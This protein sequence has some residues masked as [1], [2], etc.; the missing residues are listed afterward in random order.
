VP[1]PAQDPPAQ[2]AFHRLRDRLEPDPE[3]RWHEARPLVHRGGGG[4][5]RDDSTRDQ[6]HA[7]TREGG[8]RHGSGTHPSVVSGSNRSTVAWSDGAR[9]I[10][11]DSRRDDPAHDGPTT[12]DHLRALRPRATNRGFAPDRVR[13]D[14]GPSRWEHRQTSRDCGG[15]GRTPPTGKR[16]VHPE[17][18]GPR[19]VRPV[20]RAPAGTVVPRAGDGWVRVVTLVTRDGDLDCWAPHDLARAE[21]ERLRRAAWSWALAHGPRGEAVPRGGAGARRWPARAAEPRGSGAPGVLASGG[22][23]VHHGDQWV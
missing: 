18:P 19:P 22:S 21:R 20:A 23:R 16:H 2:E 12:T 6:P 17:R 7:P 15:R 3:T 9:P 10:P 4:L 11:C 8:G 13:F 14:R 5:G 1:P